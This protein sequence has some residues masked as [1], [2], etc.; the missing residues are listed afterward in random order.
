VTA[1]AIDPTKLSL[2]VKLLGLLGSEHAGERDTAAR[3]ASEL[4]K[5]AGTTWEQLLVP[6]Q[7]LTVTAVPAGPR[8]WVNT[9]E[10]ILEK[11]YSA[12]RITQKYNEVEFL[13]DMLTR[14][15]APSEKQKKW[16]V[17][18]ATRCGVP[19]WEGCTP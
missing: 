4:L 6:Q 5:D 9:V 8:L 15:L 7:A 3:K 1:V 13:S 12:L 17:D 18:I 10:D 16:I 14:G 19:L 11:H 2:L